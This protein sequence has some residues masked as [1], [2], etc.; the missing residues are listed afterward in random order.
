MYTNVP[1]HSAPVLIGLLLA[2]LAAPTPARMAFAWA[3]AAASDAQQ[4]GADAAPPKKNPLL[5]LAQP[6]PSADERRLRKE[7]AEAR[8]LFSRS[9]P[10]AVTITAEFRV[11]NKDHDPKSSKRYPGE[12]KHVRADGRVDAI[13]V[14][15]S[16]RGH[17]RRLARTCDYV[18]LRVEFSKESLKDTVF[19]GQSTLKL[20]VQCRDGGEYDQYILREHFA[21][22]IFNLVTSRSL[23][24]RLARVTY[25]DS[26]TGTVMGTR[27]AMFL[28]HDSDVARRMEGRSVELQRVQFKEVDA[29]T[30]ETM[31]VFAYMIGN[32]DFSIYALHNV[33]LVQTP[34]LMLYTV[35]YDF[36]ISGLV[37]PPYA[38]PMKS[39]PIKTVDDRLYRG[40]CQT[41][42]QMGSVLARFTGTRAAV[43]DLLGSLTGL[44][45]GARQETRTFLEGFYSSVGNQGTVKRVFVEQCS[46]A[47]A[48]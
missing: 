3:S 36:D 39:L 43:L 9:D 16:A 46:K 32:T 19:D 4:A 7:D 14:K 25:V 17:V 29:D 44:N 28:V 8:P 30:L 34:D 21:Y 26:T 11:I 47:P 24:T 33:V 5:K 12:L 27:Y 45:R 2:S 10:I 22:R 35:P 13:P 40:P 42:E 31:M 41:M 1:P 38:I 23:R 15:L 18:P 6:W 20:V 37:H 48:M